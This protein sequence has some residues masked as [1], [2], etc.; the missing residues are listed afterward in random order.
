MTWIYNTL[1]YLLKNYTG[2]PLP[3]TYA[4]NAFS[5]TML[6]VTI[7]NFIGALSDNIIYYVTII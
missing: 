4:M 3:D 2:D 7:L 6:K 1:C 5:N